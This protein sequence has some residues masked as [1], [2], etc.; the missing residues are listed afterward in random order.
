LEILSL[1]DD[2]SVKVRKEAI[3]HLPVISKLVS[4]QFF[5]RFLD[6]F[7]EKSHDPTNWAI[8][9]ACIDIIIDIAELTTPNNK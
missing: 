6:F 9:K 8:R 3:K 5:N 1:G 2:T 4:K 7:S